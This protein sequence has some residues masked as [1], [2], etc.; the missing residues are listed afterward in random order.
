MALE[1]TPSQDV[2]AYSCST[3]SYRAGDSIKAWQV[4]AL[5]LHAHHLIA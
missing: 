5:W 4:K 2:P 3:R 1:T